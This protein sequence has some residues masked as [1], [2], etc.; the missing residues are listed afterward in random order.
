MWMH[1]LWNLCSRSWSNLL[2]NLST[3]TLS[4]VIFSL[5]VPLLIFVGLFIY[6]F[7]HA[8]NSRAGAR[9]LLR[10]SAIPSLISAII[11]ALAWTSLFAWSVAATIYKDH[12][13]L[14]SYISKVKG[15]QA[16]EA[17]KVIDAQKQQIE[18]LKK[19]VPKLNP[20]CWIR[21]YAVPAVSSPQ[22]W[23]LSTIVCNTIVN[24]PYTV[25]LTY[26]QV[27][28][29]GPFTFPAG[30]EFAKSQLLNEG[31][32]VVAMFDLHTIIPNEPFSIMSKGS[33]DKFLLVTRGVIRA[34][35]V[36]LDLHL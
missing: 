30:S 9:D 12:Q 22:P 5:A 35:G 13:D 18:E 15:M 14:T 27:V 36:V 33:N 28:T 31:K 34:K 2:S 29:V 25:E 3:S 19:Q 23:G 1:H 26:D 11:T 32:K 16:A 4:V 17:Q 20:E 24:P 6:N 21:N 10:T 7:I 8:S